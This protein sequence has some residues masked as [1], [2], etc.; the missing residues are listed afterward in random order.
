MVPDRF[1]WAALVATAVTV[2]IDLAAAPQ[3]PQS[4]PDPI[5]KENATVKL[6]S[7]AEPAR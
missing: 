6:A 7:Y 4:L 3:P 5:V 1:A 2:R